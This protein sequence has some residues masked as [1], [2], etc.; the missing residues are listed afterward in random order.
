MERRS[1]CYP[2]LKP[3]VVIEWT[4][5]RADR[6]GLLRAIAEKWSEEETHTKYRYNVERCADGKRVYL[7]R[8]TGLNKGF[9]FQVNVE[10]LVK[11][12]KP[13]R[14]L[15]REMPAHR[16][17]IHDLQSKVAQYA[18][19]ANILFE[20]VGAVYEC[21]EPVEIL[22]R[23]PPLEA[24]TD[25]WPIDQL[26]YTVKWLFI[27]QDVTYWLHTGRDMFMSAIETEV[28]NLSPREPAV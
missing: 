14:G 25:G 19:E 27:E 3:S 23:F 1:R 22:R 28:F 8:P 17:V 13:A 5:P 20:A 26:L 11:I 18:R 24:F 16:D 15:T 10:G 12:V 9:D 2:T 21:G 6:R 7:R 4:L